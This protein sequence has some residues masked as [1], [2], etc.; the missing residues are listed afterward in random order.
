MPDGGEKNGRRPYKLSIRTQFKVWPFG[1]IEYFLE[2]NFSHLQIPPNFLQVSDAE[3]HRVWVPLNATEGLTSG[4]YLLSGASFIPVLGYLTP[5]SFS[6]KLV[7]GA[8]GLELWWSPCSDWAQPWQDLSHRHKASL[9]KQLFAKG[10]P[11]L[12]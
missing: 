3:L 12:V 10:C 8:V 9:R 2:P 5:S 7:P 4:K 6:G 11:C 1:L